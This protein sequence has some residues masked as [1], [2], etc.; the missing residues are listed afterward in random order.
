MHTRACRIVFCPLAHPFSSYCFKFWYCRFMLSSFVVGAKVI[1]TS[2]QLT[3]TH[4]TQRTSTS[5]EPCDGTS[6]PTLHPR[7]KLW[8]KKVEQYLDNTTHIIAV[9]NRKF[10]GCSLSWWVLWETHCERSPQSGKTPETRSWVWIPAIPGILWLTGW[11]KWRPPLPQVSVAI[12]VQSVASP[13]GGGGAVESAF[14]KFLAFCL[15]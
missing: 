14:K 3:C 11:Y 2:R 7:R 6:I 1:S 4:T 5:S 10:S 13:R 15:F 12:E 8:A 9:S